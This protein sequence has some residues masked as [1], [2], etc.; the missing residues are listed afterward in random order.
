[1]VT[2]CFVARDECGHS[3]RPPVSQFFIQVTITCFLFDS[4]QFPHFDVRIKLFYPGKRALRNASVLKF[5][6]N[7][8]CRHFQALSDLTILTHPVKVFPAR[9]KYPSVSCL[10]YFERT[11][12]LLSQYG[13]VSMSA[14]LSNNGK[15]AFSEF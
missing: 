2:H 14:Y 10:K 15:N 12:S 8:K 13:L 5:R 3:S 6:K 7:G 4:I 9:N 1:M 11:V